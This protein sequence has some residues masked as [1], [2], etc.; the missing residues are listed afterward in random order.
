MIYLA[1]GNAVWERAAQLTH[2]SLDR[3]GIVL[4]APDLLI[5]ACVLQADATVLTAD[6]HFQ[7]I[8]SLRVIDHL[9]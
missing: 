1:T 6:A 2:W 5:A 9:N 8:P 4:P 7:E 3:R